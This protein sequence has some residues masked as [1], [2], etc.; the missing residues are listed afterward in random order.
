MTVE[1]LAR[2]KINLTLHVTSQ[3][4]DG[5]HELDSLVAFSELGDRLTLTK[6][7]KTSLRVS[8][9]FAKGVPTDTSNLVLRAAEVMGVTA[10]I[11][12]DKRLP[13]A[14][15]IGGGS[16]DAAATLTGLAELYDLPLPSG[17]AQLCLGADVPVC[18]VGG[19]V[20]M[21]GIGDTLEA[22]CDRNAGMVIL[23]VNPKVPVATARVFACLV[24]KTNAPMD[25]PIPMPSDDAFID[26]LRKQRNDLE[27]PA[28]SVVP[29]IA[30]V[31]ASLKDQEG[32]LVA[33]MSGSG[34]TC[35]AIF[36]DE[37]VA[38]KAANKVRENRP[39]WWVALASG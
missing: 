12:L 6:A 18:V 3:R 25:E 19:V 24:S 31:L 5:Y 32:A 17:A 29:E 36:Q 20:R 27:K 30:D 21:R 7:A 39:D 23:L 11:Q 33:R 38:R 15:G 34:A 13:V 37:N 14:S 4:A 2:A 1:V 16:A 10:D 22:V 9:P 35:F 26:W 28:I 8:G